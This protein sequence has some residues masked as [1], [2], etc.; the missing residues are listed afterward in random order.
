MGE[1]VAGLRRVGEPVP[2]GGHDGFREPS[3]Y[4]QA[5]LEPPNVRAL[6]R[7]ACLADMTERLLR[8][9]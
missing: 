8:G 4:F 9:G 6:A 3:A 2:D 1:A 5:V 7:P